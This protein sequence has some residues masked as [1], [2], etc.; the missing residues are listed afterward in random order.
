M[1][2]FPFDP[3]TCRVRWPKRLTV[4]RIS[5]AV[6]VHTNGLPSTLGQAEHSDRRL[7]S[8]STL[9]SALGRSLQA[10][11]ASE[12]AT[13][14]SVSNPQRPIDVQ[15]AVLAQ[16]AFEPGTQIP[17]TRLQAPARA[18]LGKWRHPAARAHPAGSNVRTQAEMLSTLTLRN[19]A[20][21]CRRGAES[22][23][24]WAG[25][26]VVQVWCRRRENQAECGHDRCDKLHAQRNS[27][28]VRSEMDGRRFR[29]RRSVRLLA[30]GGGFHRIWRRHRGELGRGRWLVVIGR[31][32]VRSIVVRGI[33]IRGI[34]IRGIGGRII[35]GRPVIRGIVIRGIV[36]RRI[37]GR[38]IVG[39]VV[40]KRRQECDGAGRRRLVRARL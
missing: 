2:S 5:S 35:V 14:A 26:R 36:I 6:L 1:S 24:T 33:V 23:S 16:S 30:T 37:G 18:Q 34:V 29:G 20:A 13:H 4:L 27:W 40:I 15:S 9:G 11:A 7:C 3:C 8:L 10:Q 38:I 12:T 28:A 25:R 22:P 31:I 39:R 19:H 21:F 17:S 32:V